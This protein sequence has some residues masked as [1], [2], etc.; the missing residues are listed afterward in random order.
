MALF[1][2]KIGFISLNTNSNLKSKKSFSKAAKQ[3]SILPY[4]LFSQLNCVSK[5][6]TAEVK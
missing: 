1:P 2:K 6:E 5:E 4:L 3:K